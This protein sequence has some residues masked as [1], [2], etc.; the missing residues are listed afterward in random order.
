MAGASVEAHSSNAITNGED[1]ETSHNFS[2]ADVEQLSIRSLNGRVIK[3]SARTAQALAVSAGEPLGM[4][5][6]SA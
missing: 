2:L 5:H 4:S 1:A 6:V 3:Q